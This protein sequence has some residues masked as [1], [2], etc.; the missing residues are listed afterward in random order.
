[1][2]D[3][4]VLLLQDKFRED[5]D[6]VFAIGV[7]VNGYVPT[8]NSFYSKPI[9]GDK[10][11]DLVGNRSKRIFND[12][13]GI[14][15]AKNTKEGYL[16]VYH[17]DTGVKMWDVSSPIYVKGKHWGGFRLGVSIKRIEARKNTLLISLFVLFSVFVLITLSTIFLLIKR[18]M[19]PIENLTASADQISLGESLEQPIIP[20]TQDEI[21]RLTKSID[22]LRTSM[23]A[24]MERLGE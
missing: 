18:A 5:K 15:A 4:S 11:K 7:D 13:V 2:T 20:A 6:F 16:Q 1:V 22:R 24:A 14:K 12:P 8:H 10:K 3:K 9:T 21:G 23:K 17:R 19:K